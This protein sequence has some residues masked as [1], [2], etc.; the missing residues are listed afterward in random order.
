MMKMKSAFR[1]LAATACAFFYGCTTHK[2]SPKA[3][4]NL[5]YGMPSSDCA[6]IERNGYALGHKPEWKQA[7]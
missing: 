7:A 3:S 6:V 2:L 5:D 4:D 1:A